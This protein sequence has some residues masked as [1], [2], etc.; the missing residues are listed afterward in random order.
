MTRRYY[1]IRPL[2]AVEPRLVEGVPFVLSA[3]EHDGERFRVAATVATALPALSVS[4]LLAL[5]VPSGNDG[6][7]RTGAGQLGNGAFAAKPAQ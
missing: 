2:E 7:S 1:R 3:Y 6:L 4:L 5:F